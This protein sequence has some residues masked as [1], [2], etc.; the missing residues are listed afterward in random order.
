MA[1]LWSLC[2][3]LHAR[4]VGIDSQPCVCVCVSFYSL[5]APGITNNKCVLLVLL[6]HIFVHSEKGCNGGFLCLWKCQNRDKRTG[7]AKNLTGYNQLFLFWWQSVTSSQ[8]SPG[9]YSSQT[10]PLCM[11]TQILVSLVCSSLD[12]TQSFNLAWEGSS[13]PQILCPCCPGTLLSNTCGKFCLP[14][15]YENTESPYREGNW[16]EK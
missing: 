1:F 13:T 12:G 10:R 14:R 16:Y 3:K 11:V 9:Q 4:C 6:E 8:L 15:L 5:Q 7:V 2:W